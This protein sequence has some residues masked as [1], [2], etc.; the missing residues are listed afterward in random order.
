M[1]NQKFFFLSELLFKESQTQIPPT[2]SADIIQKRFFCRRL[3]S[4]VS[5]VPGAEKQ[6]LGNEV[7]FR[8]LYTQEEKHP[9]VLN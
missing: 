9:E 4:S 1:A 8:Y 6:E 2:F 3:G 5:T 7:L